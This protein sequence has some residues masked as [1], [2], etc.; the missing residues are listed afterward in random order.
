MNKIE[1]IKNKKDI[2]IKELEGYKEY[3]K[4]GSK[5]GYKK[6][7]SDLEDKKWEE[8]KRKEKEEKIIRVKD[9]INNLI[10]QNPEC[11]EYINNNMDIIYYIS[12]CDIKENI[13]QIDNTDNK[14]YEV[15]AYSNARGSSTLMMYLHIKYNDDRITNFEMNFF[16]TPKRLDEINHPLGAAIE[17]DAKKINVN[18]ETDDY[19][20]ITQMDAKLHVYE[21][22]YLKDFDNIKN[23]SQTMEKIYENHQIKET[24]NKSR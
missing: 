10:Q 18:C 5:G 14:L 24:N 15:M 17:H 23:V 16:T 6:Y 20:V 1:K 21:D 12:G 3:I 2:L 9:F 7:K 13:K 8:E 19:I 4:S 22:E 11:A